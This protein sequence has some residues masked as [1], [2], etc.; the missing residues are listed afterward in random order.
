MYIKTVSVHTKEK[1][2]I[3]DIKGTEDLGMIAWDHRIDRYSFFPSGARMS[4]YQLESTIQVLN[5]YNQG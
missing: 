3:Q 2:A 4:S 1:V 5:E